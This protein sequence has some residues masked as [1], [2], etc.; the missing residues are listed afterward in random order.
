M[1]IGHWITLG[2]FALGVAVNA[3]IV[4]KGLSDLEDRMDRMERRCDSCINR[5]ADE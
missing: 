1:E 3:G 4:W 5:S 2:L